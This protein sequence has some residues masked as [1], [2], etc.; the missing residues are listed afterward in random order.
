MVLIEARDK[1]KNLKQ[2]DGFFSFALMIVQGKI[3][4]LDITDGALWYH[5]DYV[6]PKWAKSFEKTTKIGR[7]IF[8]RERG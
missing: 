6:H 5:A 1:P 7:H 3:K 2:Y 4:L 8:Y